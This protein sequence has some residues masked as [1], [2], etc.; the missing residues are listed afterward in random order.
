MYKQQD[1]KYKIAGIATLILSF[2]IYMTG[3]AI[4]AIYHLSPQQGKIVLAIVT[5]LSFINAGAAIFIAFK[6]R[7]KGNA[8]ALAAVII[9]IIMTII[10]IGGASL[11]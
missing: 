7:N 2:G 11:L 9:S 6:L 1:K 3:G 10:S 5:V 4:Q 8:A